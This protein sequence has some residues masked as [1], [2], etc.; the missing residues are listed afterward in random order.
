[1]AF[2]T[3]PYIARSTFIVTDPSGKVKRMRP[4]SGP[5][6][7]LMTRWGSEIA[8]FK[9][10]RSPLTLV[11]RKER[12]VRPGRLVVTQV[13]PG[14]PA[15]QPSQPRPARRR[16]RAEMEAAATDGRER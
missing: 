11:V 4:T 14:L 1:M 6:K 3:R 15:R 13:T 12:E 16:A 8:M 9:S 7:K 10:C 5:R 2:A